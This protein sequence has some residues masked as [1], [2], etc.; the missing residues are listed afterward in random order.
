[1]CY[2]TVPDVET[3]TAMFSVLLVIV[4]LLLVV[5]HRK[6]IMF[7][8]HSRR[9]ER[10]WQK[11]WMTFN[12]SELKYFKNQS[13]KDKSFKNIVP[14]QEMIDIKRVHDVSATR[15]FLLLTYYCI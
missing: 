2:R 14:L 15:I 9:N 12:G 1:M 10:P 8:M 6:L 7:L 5:I 4:C 13:D 11:R 3:K